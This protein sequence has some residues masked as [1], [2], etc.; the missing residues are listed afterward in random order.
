MFRKYYGVITQTYSRSGTYKHYIIEPELNRH[1]GQ[2]D[3]LISRWELLLQRNGCLYSYYECVT[4]I[5]HGMY[6][7]ICM[8]CAVCNVPHQL[9]PEEVAGCSREVE[10]LEK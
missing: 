4:I 1:Y 6:V 9:V 5:G 8:T 2:L 7:G 10:D 3:F